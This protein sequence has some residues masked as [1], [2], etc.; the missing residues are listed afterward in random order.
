MEAFIPQ[1]AKINQMRG[2][3]GAATELMPSFGPIL[4]NNLRVMFFSFFFSLILGA[5]AVFIIVWNASILGVAIGKDATSIL[6][7][8]ALSSLYVMHG[9][10]E[11]AGYV[12]AA[13]AGGLIS[14]AIIRRHGTDV[15]NKVLIDALYIIIFAV[16]SIV[17]AAFIE[18]STGTIF[19]LSTVI[20]W[21]AFIYMILRFFLKL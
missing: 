15:L 18:A 4:N 9:V 17:L 8:P 5:G 14:V 19:M 13:L 21:G 10:P 7:I 2:M 6:D 1:V 3:T 12:A 20:W 11:I 16:F